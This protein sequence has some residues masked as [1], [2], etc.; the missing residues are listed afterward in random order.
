MKS[1]FSAVNL[2]L[3]DSKNINFSRG[4]ITVKNENAHCRLINMHSNKC[5]YFHTEQKINQ[6]KFF[7]RVIDAIES[8]EEKGHKYQCH[9]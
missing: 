4:I 8:M 7:L 6:Y 9:S 2:A 3:A 1:S 5:K